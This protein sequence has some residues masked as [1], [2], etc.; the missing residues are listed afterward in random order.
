MKISFITVGKTNTEWLKTGVLEYVKRINHYLNFEYIEISDV[1]NRN[2]LSIEKLKNTEFH[3]IS[4]FI[5]KDSFLILLDE[6]GKEY[7]SETF[8]AYIEKKLLNNIKHLI[9]VAGGAYGF[10]D[11]LYNICNDK[12]SLSQMTFSHQM[13]RLFFVEQ[14]YRAFTIIKNEKYHHK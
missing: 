3:E 2:K 8:A 5:T 14:L 4:K 9:F 12:V 6:H 7:S 1:K 13:V 11:K 10:D